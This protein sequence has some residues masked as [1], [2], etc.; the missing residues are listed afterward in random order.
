LWDGRGSILTSTTISLVDASDTGGNLDQISK[1]IAAE[2]AEG[3]AEASDQQQQQKTQQQVDEPGVPDKYR[4]KSLLD[5]I[6]MHRNAES[7]L[8]RVYNDLGTQ[9][10][11]TDRLLDLKRETDLTANQPQKVKV[12]RDE[13]LSDDPTASIERVI[14]ARLKPITDRLEQGLQ[15]VAVNS[16]ETAFISKHPDYQQVAADPAFSKWVAQSNL[17]VRSAQAAKAGDFG[18]AD[19]LLT[20]FKAS[21][22]TAKREENRDV[23]LEAARNASLESGNAP[24]NAARGKGK[25]YKRAD[26]IKLRMDDPDTYYSDDYQAVIMK[27]Y[28]EGR[29]K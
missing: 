1:Q 14:D 11:L 19:D 20:E 10:K 26:L 9:R 23:D 13:I 5:V 2:V 27:A 8:G 4:G 25:I 28:A 15:Q 3:S 18:A 6:S 21:K 22:T 17:R 12:S 24:D 29:V 16:A 7:E